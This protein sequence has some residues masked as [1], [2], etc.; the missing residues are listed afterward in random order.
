MRIR[1]K[2]VLFNGLFE[3]GDDENEITAEKNVLK[4]IFHKENR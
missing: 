1:K 2:I 4:L 3:R